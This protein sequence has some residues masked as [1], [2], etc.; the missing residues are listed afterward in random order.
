LQDQH[1][2]KLTDSHTERKVIL[3]GEEGTGKTFF[4]KKLKNK[5]ENKVI[6]VSATEFLQA[7]K[8]NIFRDRVSLIFDEA[9]RVRPCLLFIDD[10]DVLGSDTVAPPQKKVF[11]KSTE[12][13]LLR[14][15]VDS[16]LYQLGNSLKLETVFMKMCLSLERQ[17]GTTFF[18]SHFLGMADSQE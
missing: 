12:Q 3:Q 9:S 11:G 10:I 7:S 8:W 4:A 5:F 2:A 18:L 17:L 16:F 14:Q 15:V 13:A 6:F 1:R